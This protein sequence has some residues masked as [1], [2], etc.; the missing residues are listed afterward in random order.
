[1][2]C[3]VSR[4]LLRRVTT[5]ENRTNKKQ[6]KKPIALW[7]A[8]LS[9]AEWEAIAIPSQRKLAQDTQEEQR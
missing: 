6:Q 8:M 3:S 1:M 7:P 9:I 2:K 4:S 5:L